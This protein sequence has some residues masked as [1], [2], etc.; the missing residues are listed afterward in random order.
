[1]YI[2]GS[3][4]LIA[5][6]AI[7]RFAIADTIDGLSLGTIGVILMLVGALGLIVSLVQ[8]A[9]YRDGMRGGRRAGV[10]ETNRYYE[11]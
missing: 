10:V 6:G 2:G 4:A 5:F 1:M 8:T 3:I 9:M 11:P 7:L